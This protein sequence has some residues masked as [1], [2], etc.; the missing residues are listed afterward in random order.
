MYYK[1]KETP[2]GKFVVEHTLNDEDK[3]RVSKSV[4]QAFLASLTEEE[5][6]KICSVHIDVN[7]DLTMVEG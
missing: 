7:V 2:L 4:L 5:R 3:I 1:L 6:E